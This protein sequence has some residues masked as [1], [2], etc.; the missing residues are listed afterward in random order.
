VAGELVA[1]NDSCLIIYREPNVPV[2]FN[3][4]RYYHSE[5][6]EIGLEDLASVKIEGYSNNRWKWSLV[7]FEVVP[8]VLMGVAMAQAEAEN[9]GPALCILSLPTLLNLAIF[10]SSTPPSPGVEL[11]LTK[12]K[13]EELKK[14]ARFPQGLSGDQFDRLLR[15]NS[16]DRVRKIK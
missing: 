12:E 11:P 13:L 3:P 14:Y 15:M 2:S 9:I 5:F 1:V 6:F 7:A 8:T 16:Q 4:N 10:S